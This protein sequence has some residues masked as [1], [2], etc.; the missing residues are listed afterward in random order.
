MLIIPV[1]HSALDTMQSVP[2]RK[3]ARAKTLILTVCVSGVC[4]THFF[5][6]WYS[7]SSK[8]SEACL[9]LFYLLKMMTRM[10]Q[11]VVVGV[12]RA[13][14]NAQFIRSLA[15]SFNDGPKQPADK[16]NQRR[17]EEQ[18]KSSTGSSSQQGGH[19]QHQ[20]GAWSSPNWRGVLQTAIGIV[21]GALLANYGNL[22]QFLT[23]AYTIH[24]RFMKSVENAKLPALN[25]IDKQKYI[26]RA[27]LGAALK[28]F[29]DEPPA[30]QYLIVYGPK[31]SGKTTLVVQ[32]LQDREG[33]VR[34]DVGA[35]V[36]KDAVTQAIA[37]A[38]HLDGAEQVQAMDFYQVIAGCK[39]KPTIIFEI[40][41][42]KD[43]V[44]DINTIRSLAKKFAE[45]G[46]RCVLILSETT[47]AV[48]FGRDRA[49]ESYLYVGE[50][51]Q[52]EARELL[53]KRGTTLSEEEMTEVF[54]MVGTKPTLLTGLVTAEMMAAKA[55]TKLKVKDFIGSCLEQAKK[56]LTAF[57]FRQIIA[58]LKQSPSGVP[59]SQF[60]STEEKGVELDNPVLVSEAVKK[61]SAQDSAVVYRLETDTYELATT[62]HR[63]A[64]ASLLKE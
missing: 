59:T 25:E 1:V 39:K 47:T 33:V 56:E 32:E 57:R 52:E 37:R 54:K 44:G 41:R 29:V 35:A 62:A 14:P 38:L 28:S 12:I 4:L 46:A 48:V 2:S 55:N 5:A 61:F 60:L 22:R 30:Q 23:D 45:L 24:D 6:T 53:K 49:R 42:G 36:T 8:K 63:T 10:C 13:R 58:A 3:A 31:G 43:D 7:G 34:V 20:Q 51:K 26:H 17:R 19:G 15:S 27:E 18:E 50:M 9:L 64:L 21:V 40:E 11:R 16:E